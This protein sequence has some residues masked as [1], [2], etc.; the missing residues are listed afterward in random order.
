VAGSCKGSIGAGIREVDVIGGGVVVGVMYV[1][2]VGPC[3]CVG[4]G[5][6]LVS[7]CIG[8]EWDTIARS[9]HGCLR[10]VGVGQCV[11]GLFQSGWCFNGWGLNGGAV[12]ICQV[13]VGLAA[14]G[15]LGGVAGLH[16]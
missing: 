16:I 13:D 15:G 7:I 4:D 8:A 6:C 2:I 10:V 5:D 9:D 14:N 12:W 11:L 3:Q 1:G